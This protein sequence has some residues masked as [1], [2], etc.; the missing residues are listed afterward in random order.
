MLYVYLLDTGLIRDLQDYVFFCNC[1]AS[2]LDPWGNFC[3]IL[4]NKDLG[5]NLIQLN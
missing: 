4:S 5:V 1:H 3:M 2:L